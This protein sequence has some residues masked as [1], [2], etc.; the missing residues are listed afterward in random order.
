VKLSPD[1]KSL[2]PGSGRGNL[3]RR[4]VFAGVV[5][6]VVIGVAAYMLSQPRRGTVEY[7]KKKY[8]E[9]HETG[10][11][12]EWI[13]LHAP[14]AV[15]DLYW[16]PR[17]KRTDFHRN[18]LLEA[19]YFAQREFIVSNRVAKS[20][21]QDLYRMRFDVFTDTNDLAGIPV[22]YQPAANRIGV[23]ARSIDIAKWEDIIRKLDVSETNKN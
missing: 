4:W 1:A 19:G 2:P 23:L 9:A 12:G 14:V 18:A 15:H 3:S 5:V 7:H 8:L 20:L 10:P 16:K 21:A 17:E 22:F 11:V 6:T 13:I